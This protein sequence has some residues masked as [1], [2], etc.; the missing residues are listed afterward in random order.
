MCERKVFIMIATFLLTSLLFHAVQFILAQS[1]ALRLTSEK[2]MNDAF[3]VKQ[4]NQWISVI[5]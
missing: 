5:C 4:S 2:K 3:T 1:R